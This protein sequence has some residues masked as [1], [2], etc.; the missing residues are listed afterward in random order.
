[1]SGTNY[2]L[3]IMT[4]VSQL[5]NVSNVITFASGAYRTFWTERGS[6]AF[7]MCVLDS[8]KMQTT[9]I[10][11]SGMPKKSIQHAIEPSNMDI[12]FSTSLAS[13]NPTGYSVVISSRQGA[14]TPEGVPPNLQEVPGSFPSRTSRDYVDLHAPYFQ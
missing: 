10:G 9:P 12:D 13:E 1:M 7:L 5:T 6:Y 14:M 8:Y 2:L 3:L 4:S 11:H